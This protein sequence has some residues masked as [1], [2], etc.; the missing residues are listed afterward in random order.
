MTDYDR[1]YPEGLPE[2]VYMLRRA[3]IL[4]NAEHHMG[5]IVEPSDVY[6]SCGLDHPCMSLGWVDK[7]GVYHGPDE[8][9]EV[10]RCPDCGATGYYAGHQTCQYPGLVIQDDTP[11]LDPHG[12]WGAP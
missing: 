9:V 6:C 7:Q 1:P 3:G 11:A 5:T 10:A 8:K 12:P 4:E 2:G